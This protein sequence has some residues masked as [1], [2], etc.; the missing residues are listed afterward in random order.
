MRKYLVLFSF[1]LIVAC[2][3]NPD[4]EQKIDSLEKKLSDAVSTLSPMKDEIERYTDIEYSKKELQKLHQ[5][6]YKVFTF[7]ALTDAVVIEK[8][9]NEL[10]ESRWDCSSTSAGGAA[11]TIICKRPAE[12]S[13]RYVP[14][15][16]RIFP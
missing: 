4:M 3:F 2:D 10:G 8:Q 5:V 16:L 7:P 6:E 14:K 9:L 12:T 13:L 15:P 11:L 1:L